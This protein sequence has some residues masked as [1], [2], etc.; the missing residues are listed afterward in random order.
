MSTTSRFISM[1]FTALPGFIFFIL[2]LSTSWFGRE[3]WW[4]TY[5]TVLSVL[6]L[7]NLLFGFVLPSVFQS[8]RIPHPWIWILLQGFFAWIVAVC[9]LGLLNTT[10]LCVAQDNGDGNND[11]GMCM[12]MTALS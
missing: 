4:G 10:P 1:L 2:F 12:F 7:S 9:M 11:F 3:Y 8:L 5:F 6:V